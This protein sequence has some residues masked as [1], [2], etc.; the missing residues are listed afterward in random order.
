MMQSDSTVRCIDIPIEELHSLTEAVNRSNLPK[1]I[2]SKIN[3]IIATLEYLY[4]VIENKS[5]SIGRLIRMIFGAATESARNIAGKAKE[6]E[7]AVPE[8]AQADKPKRKGHGRNGA[9]AYPG[10]TIVHVKHESLSAGM[11]CPHCSEG[12]LYEQKE[13]APIMRFVGRPP[14][15][16][17][18]YE[19]EK[20][21]CNLC[22]E[23]F[24]ADLLEEAGQNKY[25][26]T[27]GAVIGVMKY[28]GG[29]PFNR[30]EQ[31]QASAGIPMPASTQ[32]EVVEDAAHRIYPAFE[33]LKKQGAQSDVIYNDDTTG[34]VVELMK[35]NDD[36]ERKGI[37]TTGIVCTGKNDEQKIALFFTGRNH[38]GEN[39]T[40]V[41]RQRNA[42]LG[43]PIQM[44]DAL[45]RNQSKE[46]ETILSNCL[47]HGR[48]NF[49]DVYD[50]FPE[51]C[52]YVIETLGK[53][54]KN[55]ET[56]KKRSLSPEE[57][58]RFHQTESG[59]VMEQLHK[60]MT[61]QLSE[62]KTEP[63]SGL[64]KSIAYMLKHW[65]KLTRFLTVAGAPLDNNLCE[66]AIKK[67]VL[68]RKNSLYYKTQC[69]AYV[70]DMFMS[71][72]HTC[73]LNNIN[74]F[75]YLTELQRNT[76]SVFKT[77]RDWMPWNYQA[78]LRALPP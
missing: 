74:P 39:L 45:S 64:G 66:R 42:G 43:A 26:E 14:I 19:L 16:A 73:N 61:E 77:P 9:S 32:W 35:N 76:A 31:L 37:F 3:L 44:C 24:Q 65:D 2:A 18:K 75:D 69:G 6:S 55:D 10:A 15:G 67:V 29:F 5:A 60:W 47:V 1:E 78:T 71:L 57:R 17:S 40:E 22:G 4:Q 8:Q 51:E 36:S 59:P 38:A 72:I 20:F 33:E 70:G 49:V 25:D 13:P 30:I 21:R 12:K 11:A 52:W 46:F 63:N 27:V 58:L 62:K 7:K 23:A 48:R 34:R 56:A 54:Y 50:N 68:H 41:L 28:G 53:V